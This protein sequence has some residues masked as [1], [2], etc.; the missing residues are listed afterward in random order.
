M[1][2]C[3]FVFILKQNSFKKEIHTSSSSYAGKRNQVAYPCYCAVVNLFAHHV[4]ASR[5]RHLNVGS[6]LHNEKFYGSFEYVIAC[7]SRRIKYE[8]FVQLAA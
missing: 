7:I 2:Y 5:S 4:V 6:A 8:N 3:N 1:Y